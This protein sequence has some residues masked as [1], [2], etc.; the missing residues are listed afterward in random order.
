MRGFRSTFILLL[1]LLGLVGYIYFYEMKR[2]AASET[3]EQKQKVFTVEADK[4]EE[5]DVKSASGERTV[6]KKSGD[7]WRIVQPIDVKADEARPPDRQQP[8]HARDP[9][10]GR[11]EG[12]RPRPVRPRDAPDRGGVQEG[13]PGRGVAPAARRQERDRRRNLRHAAGNTR[14][15]LVSSFL[16]TTFDKSTFDLRD[17]T[18][19][20][21]DRAKVDALEIVTKDSGLPLPRPARAGD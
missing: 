3:A 17:K 13:R 19:L 4:I 11:R 6:L 10:R 12:R 2:P 18:I 9:A 16:E 14:V 20:S 21:F 15:F 5:V 1:V 8:G 7:A